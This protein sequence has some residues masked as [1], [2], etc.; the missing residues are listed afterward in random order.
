MGFCT[1]C[2]NR[3]SEGSAFCTQ[4]GSPV[5]GVQP[6]QASPPEERTVVLQI[7]EEPV[8]QIQEPVEVEPVVQVQEP[9][10]VEPVIQVQEPVKV[11]EPAPVQDSGGGFVAPAVPPRKKKERKPMPKVD[12]AKL[13]GIG[14]IA[15]LV[16][17]VVALIGGIGSALYL[18]LRSPAALDTPSGEATMASDGALHVALRYDEGALLFDEAGNARME[19]VLTNVSE[20]IIRDLSVDLSF[21]EELHYV[22]GDRTLDIPVLSP[23]GSYSVSL[24]VEQVVP[25]DQGFNTSLIILI[26]LAVVV[27]ALVVGYA[28]L[29]GAHAK[30]LKAVTACLLVAALMLPTLVPIVRAAGSG[31]TLVYEDGSQEA[32][33]IAVSRTSE[34]RFALDQGQSVF[35]SYTAQYTCEQHILLD[36][37]LSEDG[38]TVTL[39]WNEISDAQQ[40]RVYACEYGYEYYELTTTDTAGYEMEAP[41]Q[42]R[43]WMFRVAAQTALGDV[44]TNDL[45]LIVGDE[46]KLFV[47]NDGDQLSNEIEE[48]FGTSQVLEDTDG[49]G[50]SDYDEVALTMTDPLRYDSD[51]DGVGDGDADQDGDGLTSLRELELGTA[52]LVADSDSDGLDD[53]LEQEELGT[54]PLRKDTDGDGLRDGSENT[55]GTDPTKADTDEDGVWDDDDDHAASLT[56]P[57]SPGAQLDVTDSGDRLTAA[58][59]RDI[60]ED[61]TFSDQEYVASPV[62]MV[63]IPEDTQGQITLPI[64]DPTRKDEVVIA[65]YKEEDGDFRILED[66]QVSED[67]TSVSVDVSKEYVTEDK[68]YTDQEWS[69]TTQ[70]STYVA[71]Y[72]A[73]WH[74]MFQAPL[75]P[76]RDGNVSFDVSFVIDESSSMEDN[77]KGTVND[78]ERYRVEAA[79]RFT[80]ALVAGDRAAVVGF[81]EG[82]RRKIQLSEDMVAVRAA[83]DSIVGNAGGTALYA[84]LQEALAEL[85]A[86]QQTPEDET[87]TIPTEEGTETVPTEEETETVPTEGETEDAPTEEGTEDVPTEQT[88]SRG[89][90]I[91]ALT[92]GED[93]NSDGGAYDQ[94]I[95]DC[96]AHQIPIYTIGLGSSVNTSLLTKLA[97]YTGG[98]YI[99]IQNADDLPQVF[100]RIENTAFYGDDTDGDG[101]ADSVEEHG[102]RDGSGSIYFTDASLRFTDEDDLSD[103]EE[104]GNVMYTEE[105]ADGNVLAYYIMLTDPSQGD[106]DGDGVDDLDE[107]IMKTLPWCYD[108]D[109]DGLS[110][111]E[112]LALGYDPVDAN[113]DGDTYDD[114]MEK[115]YSDWSEYVAYLMGD[116]MDEPALLVLKAIIGSVG[117]RDPYSYDLSGAEKGVALLEGALLGDFGEMLTEYGIVGSQHTSSMYYYIGG[118][119]IG[120]IPIASAVAAIRDAIAATIDGDWLGALLSLVGIIPGGGAVMEAV[121]MIAEIIGYV[122]DAAEAAAEYPSSI[123]IQNAAAAPALTYVL[124]LIY[125]KIEVVFGLD[126][127]TSQVKKMVQEQADLGLRGLTK[128]RVENWEAFLSYGDQTQDAD[129]ASSWSFTTYRAQDALEATQTIQL[130]I[131]NESHPMTLVRAVREAMGQV[132]GG[133]IVSDE[134]GATYTLVRALDLESTEYQDAQ[135]LEKALEDS[136]DRVAG[137]T[138]P[139]Y[140]DMT[141]RLQLVVT[142]C[143]VS[144]DAYEA[145]E[146]IRGYAQDKGVVLECYLYMTTDD[147]DYNSTLEDIQPASKKD[148]IIILPGI[149]AS[150]LVAGE[151]YTGGAVGTVTEG[152]TIWLPEAGEKLFESGAL[153]TLEDVLTQDGLFE[154]V[155][156]LNMLQLDSRGNSLYSVVPAEVNA[157]NGAMNCAK[158]MREGIEGAFGDSHDVVFFSYDWRK[159]V[160]TA[161]RD[162]QTYIQKRGYERVTFIC[163]SMGGIVCS[164]Y[165]TLGQENVDKTQQVITIGT[166]YGGAPKAAYV[167]ETGRFLEYSFPLVDEAFMQVARNYPSVY[168]L[169]PYDDSIAHNGGYLYQGKTSMGADATHDY[170]MNNDFD[171]NDQMIGDALEV[172]QRLYPD[173][174][175]IMETEGLDH[176]IIAGYGTAT[177]SSLYVDGDRIESV[178]LSLSGDGTVPLVSAI[179]TQGR[180]FDSPIYL[181]DGVDHSGLFGDEDVIALVI[182]L[183][184]PSK[185]Q[186]YDTDKISQPGADDKEASD[187]ISQAEVDSE[188][189]P[190]KRDGAFSDVYDILVAYCPVE[191]ELYDEQGALVGSVGSDGISVEDAA[192]QVLFQRLYGGESKQV[193]IPKGYSVKVLGESKGQMDLRLATMNSSGEMMQTYFYED[194]QVEPEMAVEVTVEDHAPTITVDMDGDGTK[195]KTLEPED[196]TKEVYI[197]MDSGDD[198]DGRLW[199]LIGIS[200]GLVLLT[201]IAL[202]LITVLT[203]PKKGKKEE[204]EEAAV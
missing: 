66:S 165:L 202:V 14:K 147:N 73:N 102:L 201:G 46:G 191:L 47:D 39:Q 164:Y 135:V 8:V 29:C 75:S 130:G 193:I 127:G 123:T 19:L 184:D 72:I 118:I 44:Y 99:H 140:G 93:S 108:T 59:I 53:G 106:T 160:G 128:D 3:L 76:D 151:D 146:D 134:A 129:V 2:G 16:L 35:F 186:G 107:M 156:S 61:T 159:S 1:K 158:A 18:S 42:G 120:F 126:L 101:L 24:P 169:L 185:A 162:L 84:G 116:A 69:V 91:I 149:S 178:G 30:S 155:Q 145:L 38:S 166:P 187:I 148:A 26:V 179:E 17:I 139:E 82:A 45:Q 111:G 79:K 28:L 33:A 196:G 103:G 78:P 125:R 63:Q 167:F 55:I 54:D 96:V 110:D 34:E 6:G 88:G 194:L 62:I 65:V 173:G 41:S 67:G 95:A 117:H 60:T 70:R 163:H 154:V 31:S 57:D 81:N 51:G 104:A 177:V 105:D 131:T 203:S 188:D 64:H 150:E 198:G 137:Y 113:P 21:P 204:K 181:V 172:Q 50:I 132:P 15:V 112:E 190:D 52:P 22:G 174:R 141:K 27:I 138:D 10:E 199:V 175:H 77:A 136:V 189:A 49:D 97:T 13:L 25:M 182:G 23:G 86:S 176:T 83:I 20:D 124:L 168:E 74:T 133:T 94:I 192:D 109:G 119:I 92:D 152:E 32:T 195:E 37:A 40:Y 157:S 170:L 180:L 9:V 171:L 197:P 121:D 71:F 80:E 12:P 114:S 5:L 36:A 56:D 85:I 200:G 144:E 90:F 153:G 11:E 4:C 89:R 48:A 98:T 87:E 183:I 43:I 142:D 115:M 161:A 122:C 58:Q 7:P 143:L 68:R 100:N